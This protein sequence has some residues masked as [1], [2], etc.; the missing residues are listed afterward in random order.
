MSRRLTVSL[1]EVDEALGK[2]LE[3]SIAAE[4]KA[5]KRVK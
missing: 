5:G 1:R 4:V 2:C 3:S